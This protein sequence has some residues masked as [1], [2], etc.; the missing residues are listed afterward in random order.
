MVKNFIAM[1]AILKLLTAVVAIS[2]VF[3]I[4][5]TNPHWSIN[6]FGRQT[7]SSEWWVSGAGLATS[8]VSCLMLLS[9]ILMLRRRRWGRQVYIFSWIVLSLLIPIVALLEGVGFYVAAPSLLSNL[10]LTA[11]VSVYLYKSN[12]V[13][14]YF[15]G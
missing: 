6:V 3:C 11:L 15:S 1:P 4:G 7:T 12:A 2:L 10:V 9:A 13:E 8:I 14:N 5:S